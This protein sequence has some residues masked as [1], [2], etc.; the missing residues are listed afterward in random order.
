MNTDLTL[1][2][3]LKAKADEMGYGFYEFGYKA[4]FNPSTLYAFQTRCP[5]LRS[6]R[7]I[8]EFIEEDLKELRQLPITK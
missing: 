2:E 5:S 4:G 8:A 6:Y 7:K 3:Y 1:F